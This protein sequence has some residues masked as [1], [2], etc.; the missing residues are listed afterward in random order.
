[1][2]HITGYRARLIKKLNRKGERYAAKAETVGISSVSRFYMIADQAF[3]TAI[4]LS[5]T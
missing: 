5:R 1:M 2:K 3:R 4:Q